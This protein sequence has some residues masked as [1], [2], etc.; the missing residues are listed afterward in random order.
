MKLYTQGRIQKS[1]QV[2]AKVIVVK[3]EGCEWQHLKSS[4]QPCNVS[5]K[6]DCWLRFDV[7]SPI[8]DILITVSVKSEP[9]A[10]L[11]PHPVRLPCVLLPGH[12][13]LGKSVLPSVSC[14]ENLPTP[15]QRTVYDNIE[16]L[17]K[18]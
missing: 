4:S 5:R 8:L 16:H 10:A 15:G 2:D 6:Y 11:W 14:K 9:P 13:V 3:V 17:C 18:R 7:D 12:P 1:D